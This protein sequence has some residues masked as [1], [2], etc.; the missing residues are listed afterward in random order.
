MSSLYQALVLGNQEKFWN[1]TKLLKNPILHQN[2]RKE[3]YEYPDFESLFKSS[4]TSMKTLQQRHKI[5][6]TIIGRV[7]NRHDVNLNEIMI[8]NQGNRTFERRMIPELYESQ[9]GRYNICKTEL[10]EDRLSDGSYVSIDHKEVYANEGQT[11]PENAQLVDVKCN[12]S[13]GAIEL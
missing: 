2:K 13:K 1:K 9:N 7:A 4:K 5:L 3:C 10:D 8:S 6:K 12:Q 11:I